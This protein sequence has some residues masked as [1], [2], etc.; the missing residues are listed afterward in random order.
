MIQL[1][2]SAWHYVRQAAANWLDDKALQMGAV[3]YIIKPNS[4]SSLST[5]LK[6]IIS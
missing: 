6:R 4:I 5:L 3:D 1:A 2:T